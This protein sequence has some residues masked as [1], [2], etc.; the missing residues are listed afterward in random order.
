MSEETQKRRSLRLYVYDIHYDDIN[1]NVNNAAFFNDIVR[2]LT[3]PIILIIYNCCFPPKIGT[4][5]LCGGTIARQVQSWIDQCNAM[6][7]N[8]TYININ[9]YDLF[10]DP[11][12]D[13]RS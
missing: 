12:P 3:P 7:C 2:S 6:Q 4:V 13:R 1:D 5:K 8:G 10:Y 11:G 9:L